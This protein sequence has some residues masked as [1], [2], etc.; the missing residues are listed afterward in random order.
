MRHDCI[1]AGPNVLARAVDFRAAVG[2]DAHA[3]LG[4]RTMRG[5]GRGGHPPADQPVAVRLRAGIL[6]PLC[7]A[8]LFA[9][10]AVTLREIPRG[11]REAAHRV[12]VGHVGQP[13]RDGVHLQRHRQFV[14]GRLEGIDPGRFAGRA[15]KGRRVEVQ[16]VDVVVDLDI[17]RS[18]EHGGRGMARTF[19]E[20]AH[21]TCA[22]FAQVS[23]GLE[24]SVRACAKLEVLR[25]RR[26]IADGGEHVLAFH[27]ELHRTLQVS[28]GRGDHQHVHPRRALA[29]EATAD[30]MTDDA[31]MVRRDGQRLCDKIARA[32]HPLRRRIKRQPVV[33]PFGH[34][35]VRFHRLVVLDWRDV[36]DVDLGGAVLPDVLDSIDAGCL[37]LEVRLFA[38]DGFGHGQL[39]RRKRGDGRLFRVGRMHQAGAFARLLVSFRDHISDVLAVVMDLV[40]RQ[41]SE[42]LADDDSATLG[43]FGRVHPWPVLRRVDRNHAGKIFRGG[44]IEI[45]DAALRHRAFDGAG[46]GHVRKTVIGGVIGLAGDLQ[47]AVDATDLRANQFGRDRGSGDVAHTMARAACKA[48]KV[49]RFRSSILN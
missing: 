11:K 48:R 5:I 44:G 19:D 17:G 6:F 29:T 22:R 14:H 35:R 40:A 12:D 20:I 2:E 25:R 33:I 42:L 32:V 23:H 34:H 36:G 49:V 15:H 46:P 28:R 9:A 31:D 21:R 4:G 47:G 39:G 45:S 26:A 38:V 30:K 10:N 16:L 43:L 8:E 41:R 37:F 3:R 27:H 7:P 13:Q 18:V 1:G 24:F